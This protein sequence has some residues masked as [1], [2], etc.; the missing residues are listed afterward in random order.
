MKL[1][2]NLGYDAR[3]VVDVT[4]S[5]LETLG[6]VLEKIAAVEESWYDREKGFT[7]TRDRTL[8]YELRIL[9]SNIIIRQPAAEETAN[10]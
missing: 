8:N 10:G 4:S 2:L 1:Y 5:E 3:G 7:L 6:R 9:P